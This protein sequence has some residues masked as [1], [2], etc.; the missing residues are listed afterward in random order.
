MDSLSQDQQEPLLDY[1][2]VVAD[3]LKTEDSSQ[4]ERARGSRRASRPK[5]LSPLTCL[6]ILCAVIA[7][8]DLCALAYMQHLWKTSYAAPGLPDLEFADPYIGLDDLY[9]SGLVHSPSIPPIVLAP[10]VCAPVFRDQPDRLTPVGTHDMWSDTWGTTSPNERH[11]HVNA[12]TNTVIQFRTIDYGMEDCVLTLD[13]P[14]RGQ[15]LEGNSTF[16][17]YPASQFDV[18]L[19]DT[20]KMLKPKTL[21]WRTKPSSLSFFATFT[22]HAGERTFISRFR[23]PRG[24]LFTFEFACADQSPCLVHT[25][26]SQNYTWGVNIYQHQ[27]V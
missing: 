6:F 25:W 15:A 2:L 17:L 23:C 10:R 5:L 4:A 24:S 18:F 3:N 27:T 19:A 14:A 26:S 7:V 16:L 1:E 12:T 8:T 11:L 20:S 22:P 9:R 13:L 21:S